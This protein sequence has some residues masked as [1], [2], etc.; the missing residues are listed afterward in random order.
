MR[1]RVR[2]TNLEVEIEDGLLHVLRA[3]LQP[4]HLGEYLVVDGLVGLDA[5]DQLVLRL[6]A[7]EALWR[8]LLK[9][10]PDESLR[11][12]QPLARLQDERHPR[13]SLVVEVE[14]RHSEGRA[15]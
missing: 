14:H 3:L 5:Y 10:E 1:V 11:R 12:L 6:L 15:A 4:G 8:R 2:S 13:P 9:L 7:E